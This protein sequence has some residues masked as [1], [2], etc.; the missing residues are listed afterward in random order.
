MAILVLEDKLGI[1]TG[2]MDVWDNLVIKAGFSPQIFRRYSAWKSPVMSKY[3]LL[4]KKG[5]RKSPGFNQEIQVPLRRWLDETIRGVFPEFIVCMDVA[6]LGLFEANWNN[7]TL[8]NMRGGVYSYGSTPVL[9]MT[10]ISAVNR[11]RQVKDVRAMNDGAESEDEWKEDSQRDPN[12]L[13]IEPYTIRSGR[14][15]FQ[16]DLDKLHRLWSKQVRR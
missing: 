8:D 13:F 4:V 6:L 1:T 5:N 2:Y 3:T 10:P 16:S 12:E 7:A 11:Q 9:I 14:W 15:I